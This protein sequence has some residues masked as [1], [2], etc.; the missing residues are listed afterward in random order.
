[1]VNDPVI[2]V[3]VPIYKTERYIERCLNSIKAQTFKSFE[4]IMINDG[5]PDNS[6][7]IAQAFTSDPRFILINQDNGGV[8]TVRNLGIKLAKG[9]YI[10]FI[11]S[12][13]SVFPDHLEK[14]YNAA[15]A[16]DADIVCSSYCCCDEN[17]E[18]IRTSKL[19]KRKGVYHAGQ[20]I[21][22][23]IRDI[24][25]RRYLW[26]KLWRRSLFVDNN[27]SF[28]CTTY[29]DACIIPILFY[30]ARTV[31]VTTDRTYIYTNRASSITGLSSA[32]CVGDYLA[33][34]EKV[35]IYFLSTPEYMS[36]IPH[37]IYQR[38]KTV[39]VTFSWL[40]I[41]IFRV[42]SFNHFGVDL[43]KIG[44]FAISGKSSDMGHSKTKTEQNTDASHTNRAC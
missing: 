5:S 3:I 4:V 44:K 41:R 13:D 11:D 30:N 21:G 35:E 34:N 32:N 1:M 24:S 8:G 15:S 2:S 25:I 39:M 23:I 18:H 22:N 16:A 12:D 33:A 40:F 14:L 28:P 10:A 19:T 42:R 7:S 36:Y 31:A 17:G 43:K 37:L 20:L 38:C 27:I 6:A 29:E 26:N 9:K